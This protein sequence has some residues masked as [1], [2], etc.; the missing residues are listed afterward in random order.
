MIQDVM[1]TL[2]K[3][4]NAKFLDKMKLCWFGII[5]YKIVFFFYIKRYLF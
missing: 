2:L 1:D 5:I 4:Y 3:I